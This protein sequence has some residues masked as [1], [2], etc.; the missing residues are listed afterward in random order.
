M[1][2]RELLTIRRPL[3]RRGAW[4]CLLANLLVI[5][6]LGSVVAGW[7]RGY[8]QMALALTGAGLTL[9]FAIWFFREYWRTYA[10]PDLSALWFRLGMWGVVLFGAGWFWALAT[11]I[12]IFNEA[13]RQ[14]PAR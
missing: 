11:G 14:P 9:G 3:D 5:P 7:R 13:N 2:L 4:V 1:I 12:S 10:V 8:A 6:G